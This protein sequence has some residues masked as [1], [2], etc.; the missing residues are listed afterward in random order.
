MPL[1]LLIVG[2]RVHEVGYRLM[3]L[4]LAMRLGLRRFEAY[5][6]Y[7]D[8]R[9]AVEVLADGPEQK[10]RKLVDA[11]KSIKPPQAKVDYVK[12]E[13][14]AGDEIQE[15][16]DYATLLQLEQ[17]IKG[18]NYIAKIL[19]KQDEMLKRQDEMLRKQDEMLKKQDEM[20]KKQDEMLGKQDEMLKKQSEMLKKQDEVIRLLKKMSE[21][22]GR[23]NEG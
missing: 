20:L 15:T 6:T 9:Q 5:N 12:A 1:R 11:V 23:R 16:R 18:V 14:Y 17:L 19:E 10:L 7:H 3:L 8:G 4:S 2:S 22:G 13:E 21:G